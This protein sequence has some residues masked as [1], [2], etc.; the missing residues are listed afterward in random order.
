MSAT[1]VRFGAGLF[2]WLHPAGGAARRDAGVV[3]CAP[4]GYEALCTYRVHRLLAERLASA[5]FAVLRFDWPGT[6]DSAGD[7]EEPARVRAWLDGLGAA[8]D[9]LRARAGVSQVCLYGLRLGATLALRGAAERGDVASIAAWSPFDS[10]RL[11]VREARALSG[12]GQEPGQDLEVAGFVVTAAAQVELG[13]LDLLRLE[14]PPAPRVLIVP[15]D[16]LPP[17]SKLAAHL[18]ALGARVEQRVLPGYLQALQDAHYAQE[19]KATFAA[20][21][22]WLAALHPAVPGAVAPA[23]P[24]LA[25]ELALG[26]AREVP[27]R[28]GAGGRLFGVLDEPV[29]RAAR[30]PALVFLNTGGN[31]RHGVSRMAVTLGRALAAQGFRALRFDTGGLGDSD[32]TPGEERR[33]YTT[34]A[35]ADVV[36]AIDWLAATGSDRFVLFGIC[37]GAYLAFHAGVADPRVAGEVLVNAQRFIWTEGDSLAVTA[38]RSY[39]SSRFYLAAAFSRKTWTRALRGEVNVVGV[40]RTM[41]ARAARRTLARA[42]ELL[43][44]GLGAADPSPVA[45]AFRDKHRRGTRVLLVYS[46]ADGGLDEMEAHLGK[47]ARKLRG[48]SSVR[49]TIIHGADHTFTSRTARAELRG[50]VVDQL[51]A[52]ARE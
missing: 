12:A 29:G 44:H 43:A 17:G 35:V 14:R 15:R 2:G 31:P 36:A 27:V 20:I 38:R 42:R 23:P 13:A 34:A 28:F 47:D 45:R 19:P 24:P 39:K 51:E 26:G 3:V 18:T 46:H 7:E 22:E 30:G 10:G 32:A 11:F 21:V 52:C 9:E 5:G 25:A 50:L 8:I 49:T 48:L 1:P 6:G 37:S 41:A 33:L 40:V 16:D 4:F